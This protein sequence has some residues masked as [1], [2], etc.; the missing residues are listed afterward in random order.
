MFEKLAKTITTNAANYSST[1]VCSLQ[2]ARVRRAWER[3]GSYGCRRHL[4]DKAIAAIQDR[5]MYCAYVEK[6]GT[7]AGW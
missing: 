6:H 3:D 7:D 1:T 5:W 2:L 4:L